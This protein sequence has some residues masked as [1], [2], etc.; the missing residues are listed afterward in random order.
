MKIIF[1]HSE[2]SDFD[3]DVKETFNSIEDFL[4]KHP[5]YKQF[6][7]EGRENF[8]Q[9]ITILNNDYPFFESVEIKK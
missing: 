2:P 6:L 3:S 7:S 1:K 5:L 4:I 9:K 8:N